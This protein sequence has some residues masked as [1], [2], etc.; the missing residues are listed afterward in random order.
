M[1]E[2]TGVLV[3]G[4]AGG[5]GGSGGSNE[6]WFDRLTTNGAGITDS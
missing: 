2:A 1:A 5:S 3:L 4:D 6:G